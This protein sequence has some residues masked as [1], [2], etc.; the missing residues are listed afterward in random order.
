MAKILIIEDHPTNRKL[1]ADLLTLAGHEV[2]Q[3]VDAQQG[4]EQAKARLPDL[5]VMDIQ[6]PGMD[7]LAATRLLKDE[8]ATSAIKIIALT[9]FAMKGDEEKFRAAGCDAYLAKPI[10]YREFLE[11]VGA[12]VPAPDSTEGG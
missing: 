4:I 9:A 6:L 7:G 12:L 11:A 3:A 10:H 2:L 1:V 5:I 8:P